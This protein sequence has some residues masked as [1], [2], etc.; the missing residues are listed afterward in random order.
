METKLFDKNC[1]T[2]DGRMDEPVWE[3]VEEYSGFKKLGAAGIPDE[4]NP[5]FFK[6]LPCADRI[7]IGVKCMESDMEYH[8]SVANGSYGHTNS[9]EL[10]LS[11]S[12]NFADFYQ[13]FIT[14]SGS[15]ESKYYEERGK[16]RT[17]MNQPTIE[18]TTAEIE[19]ALGI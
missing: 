4:E 14:A 19:K 10:F 16:L 7:Y 13:F 15:T 1:I 11:P 18:A 8:K 3:T 2:L 6:I 12:G 9:I 5:T 17:V